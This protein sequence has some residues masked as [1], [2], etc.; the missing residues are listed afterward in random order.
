MLAP[1]PP[2][3][4]LQTSSSPEQAS[5]S[6]AIDR[7][8]TTFWTLVERLRSAADQQP[9]IHQV[10]AAVFQDL[11]AMG[12]DLLRAFL[13]HSGV[14]DAGPNLTVPGAGP[15][16]PPP[17]LPRLDQPRRRPSLSIFGAVPIARI[18]SGH[19]RLEAAPLDAR[20]HL[21]RRPD[22][23][24]FPPWLG[25]FV[26][27]EAPAV[28]LTKLPTILGLEVAVNASED[29]NREQGSDVE[30]FPNHLPTPEAT[31][32]G[33]ILVVTADGNG[34]PLIRTALPPEEETTDPP[35]PALA[36]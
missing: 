14:G 34:V 23:D 33:P 6:K 16:D 26:V 13:A 17:I 3:V 9:P 2:A 20:L 30:P 18:G 5:C 32:E 4:T 36:N 10:E 15:D 21:P 31:A 24:L 29:H 12:R 28:A 1:T 22:S 27:D 8:L 7:S 19:D 25:V 35:L 11:L